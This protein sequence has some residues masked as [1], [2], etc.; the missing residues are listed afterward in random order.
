VHW[1]VFSLELNGFDK[2]HEEFDP[3][4]SKSAPSLRTAVA[5]REA[6]GE[7]A[8]GRFYAAI[9]DRYFSQIQDLADETTVRGALE[10]CGLDPGYYDKA[11][12]DPGTWDTVRAEHEQLVEATGAFG[13]PTIRLDGGK[14]LAI[15]GPVITEPPPDE[16]AVELWRHTAW[17]VRNANF[18]ELK[19]NRTSL[20]DLPYIEKMRAERAAAQQRV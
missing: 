8:C 2:P 12:G 17:L 4:M 7:A 16:E 15:F 6:E 14:G 19:R 18:H 11:I 1:G 13:V 20:P 9:G 10:D 3:T 5:V